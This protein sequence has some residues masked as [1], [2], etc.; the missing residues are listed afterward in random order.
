MLR[1][2]LGSIRAIKVHKTTLILT[3]SRFTPY[4]P[5]TQPKHRKHNRLHRLYRD[6]KYFVLPWAAF[7]N[8]K[9]PSSF[10]VRGIWDECDKLDLIL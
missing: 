1:T 10:P 9:K 2:I 6:V 8:V 7:S 4:H 3:T 5:C